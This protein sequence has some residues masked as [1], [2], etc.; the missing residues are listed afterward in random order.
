MILTN[1]AVESHGQGLS[2]A[3]RVVSS[4]FVEVD[5]EQRKVAT[6]AKFLT[7][8]DGAVVFFVVVWHVFSYKV[9]SQ[10]RTPVPCGGAW[11]PSVSGCQHTQPA[12]NKVPGAVL[13]PFGGNPTK[14][15]SLSSAAKVHYFLLG[16]AIEMKPILGLF[17]PFFA[18]SARF[19]QNGDFLAAQPPNRP[20]D[21]P[22][23]W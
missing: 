12:Q 9:S 1:S 4:G 20:F 23:R 7:S 17:W 2:N 11:A 16:C 21:R 13:G 5:R 18:C 15:G 19:G 14:I 22:A 10:S 8:V 6:F 3:P